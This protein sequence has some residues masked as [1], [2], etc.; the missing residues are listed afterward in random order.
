LHRQYDSLFKTIITGGWCIKSDGEVE[1]SSGYFSLTEIPS[2]PG[3][4][5]EMYEAITDGDTTTEHSLDKWPDAGWY[6]TVELNTGIIFVFEH[7]TE[8]AAE[9]A[10]GEA[11][12]E[13]M[14]WLNGDE[15]GV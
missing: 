3:E 5:K 4:L 13:Y 15:Y 6:T 14:R 11:L 12:A 2:H 9:I 1:A 8:Q 10:Y 7:P